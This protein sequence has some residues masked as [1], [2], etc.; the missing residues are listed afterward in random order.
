M[1]GDFKGFT[2][3]RCTNCGS[4]LEGLPTDTIFFCTQCGRCHVSGETLSPV[5][6]GFFNHLDPGGILLPFWRV[7]AGIHISKRI[8]RTSFITRTNDGFRNFSEK[9]RGLFDAGSGGSRRDVLIFPAFS[10]NL[11]LST[12]VKL[13]RNEISSEAPQ[14][15]SYR[16]VIG[17]SVGHDSI[18]ELAEGVAVGIDVGKSDHLAC[19]ELDLEI[20]ST[21]ILA[22]GCHILK[23]VFI[24]DGTD[25][26][27]P[28]T[29]VEDTEDILRWWQDHQD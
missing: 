29:A 28:F 25:I 13:H 5:K 2:L 19:I 26:R 22:M 14:Y 23:H 1:I 3:L 24:I 8:T 9:N 10:T 27:I 20:I 11:V 16:P 17:G 7:E 4:D 12:G 15:G 21:G 18:A 6:I